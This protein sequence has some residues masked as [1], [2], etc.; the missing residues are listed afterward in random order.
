MACKRDPET[1]LLSGCAEEFICMCPE[2]SFDDVLVGTADLPDPRDV[3]PE[4][5]GDIGSRVDC[6]LCIQH[7]ELVHDLLAECF[8]PSWLGPRNWTTREELFGFVRE[9]APCVVNRVRT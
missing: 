6:R 3:C 2:P 4:C 5:K 9:D 8:G 1:G 7:R